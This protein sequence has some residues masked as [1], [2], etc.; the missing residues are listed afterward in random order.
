MPWVMPLANE[1]RR[2]RCRQHLG[3]RG[4][5]AVDPA[6]RVFKPQHRMMVERPPRRADP[7]LADHPL[8]DEIVGKI[9]PCRGGTGAARSPE[10]SR[11]GASV[12]PRNVD[13]RGDLVAVGRRRTRSRTRSRPRAPA[14]PAR[15]HRSKAPSR[16]APATARSSSGRRSPPN[17][18]PRPARRPP[19]AIATVS[20]ALPLSTTM[21]SS[22]N[23]NAREA[24]RDVVRLVPG[25]DD[26]AQL[27]GGSKQHS[28]ETGA[29]SAVEVA[30]P[31]PQSETPA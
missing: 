28:S 12:R 23:G 17:H 11:N 14:A 15:R 2:P 30:N 1:T 13:S 18:G 10:T 25:D 4:R 7:A 31:S 8:M 19:P 16:R 27:H 20:S 26:R 22:Q 6:D 24:R 3:A 29:G 5:I 21:R 9:A